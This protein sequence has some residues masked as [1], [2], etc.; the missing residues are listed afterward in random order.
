MHTRLL[1][2][3][4]AALT[5]TAVAAATPMSASQAP[6]PAPPSPSVKAISADASVLTLTG[7]MQRRTP[8]SSGPVGTA[9]TVGG[10]TPDA[11]F[12]LTNVMDVTAPAGAP[13]PDATYRLEAEDG[14]LSPHVGHKV[15]ITGKLDAAAGGATPSARSQIGESSA[16]AEAPRIKVD[17]VKM[18]A[19]SCPQ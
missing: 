1:S 15:E 4:L 13:A 12:V 9:G 16:S 14:K 11:A 19:S 18:L 10:N 6:A 17:S 2:T 3:T 8:T 5:Y 7:C